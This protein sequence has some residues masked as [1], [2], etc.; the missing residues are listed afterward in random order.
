MLSDTG[1]AASRAPIPGRAGLDYRRD[2][3]GLRA[4]A[5]L[6][7]VLHHAGLGLASGGFVGVDIFFVI[8]GFLITRILQADVTASN[9]R[10]GAFYFRRAKRLLP[11]LYAMMLATLVGG[12]WILTPSDYSLLGQ[13]I[14]S[15]IGLFSNHFFWLHTGG[16]FSS[17]AS[18]FPLLHVWSLS[19]EEQFYL[20]WPAVF[21]LVLRLKSPI[22]RLGLICLL[23]FVS[24]VASEYGV[25]KNW[26]GS[27]FLAPN[28]AFEFLIGALVHL[29]WRDRGSPSPLLANMCSGLGLLGALASFLVLNERSGFPGLNA[30]FPC[31]SAALIIAAPQ[32]GPSLGSRLLGLGPMVAVGLASYSIYLWHW[33]LVSYLKQSDVEF[34]RLVRI[35]LVLAAVAAGFISWWLI[36]RLFRARLE[37]NDKFAWGAMLAATIALVGGAGYVWVKQG[38]PERF[39]Y[40]MLTEDQLMSERARYWRDL[41]AKNTSFGAPGAEAQLLIVGNSHAFD[42]AYALGENGYP[43]KI[44]IVE[45]NHQCFNF[46][47]DPVEPAN[48]AMCAERLR[49]VL[50]SPDVKVA[51][52]IYLHD[53]WGRLDLA[54]LDDMILRLRGLTAAP[55]YVFGPKMSFSQSA[56]NIAKAAQNQPHATIATINR[57]AASY[58]VEDKAVQDAALKAHFAARSMPGVHYVSTMDAQCGGA[59]CPLISE[60]GKYLFFDESH[61]TLEGS[62]RFGASLRREHPDLFMPVMS[63]R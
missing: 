42:L 59:I 60:D 33:P 37:K 18:A 9:F 47:H 1:A 51:S 43:G 41:P 2:I 48:T 63:S 40:A 17:D 26:T 45:T 7:V 61:F 38:L 8:S 15:A 56:L 11:A 13:S 5:V 20:V 28:R 39:P 19:V 54:G 21:I 14:L 24:L 4:V 31:L 27:Y 16:Y 35:G 6:M 62:R 29:L 46:G 10:F 44:K 30:L 22:A 36:E 49:A 55:I 50:T 52:A 25:A 53:N 57:F 32:F 58:R 12:Y 23:A 3:D 34:T